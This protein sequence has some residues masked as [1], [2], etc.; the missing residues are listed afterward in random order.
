MTEIE[1][2]EGIINHS[3]IPVYMK[4]GILRYVID[5]VPLG[6]FLEAVF[7]NDLVRAATKADDV[8][9]GHLYRYAKL[10]YHLP[11]ACWGS[12]DAIRKW[13]E[14]GGARGRVEKSTN[15]QQENNA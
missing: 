1:R 4:P 12:E 3:A 10:L 8:N 2:L 5:G 11:M 6:G 15:G 9:S 14:G 7:M 13:C